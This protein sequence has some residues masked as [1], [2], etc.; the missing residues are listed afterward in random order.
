[1]RKPLLLSGALLALAMASPLALSQVYKW[2]DANGQVHYGDRAPS[3]ATQVQGPTRP[4]SPQAEAAPRPATPPPGTSLNTGPAQA[5]PQQAQQVK[6]DVDAAR[7]Q[8][9]KEARENYEKSIRA[10]RIF[11]TNDKGERV[12]MSVQEADAA[13]L[14]L[15]ASVDATC[16]Q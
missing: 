7:V 16:G 11:T 4:P 15:K 14:Q 8:Q 12:Y 2:T 5:T 13:R 3:N 1:M 9:C 6:R 10:Q